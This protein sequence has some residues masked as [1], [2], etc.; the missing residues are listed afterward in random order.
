MIVHLL[1][2]LIVFFLFPFVSVSAFIGSL[3]GLCAIACVLW[4]YVKRK[5]DFSPFI[6]RNASGL[7]MIQHELEQRCEYL[8]IPVFS[9]AE[10]E[11]ATNKFNSSRK[12]G[13][14]GYGTVYYGKKVFHTSYSVSNCLSGF[15]LARSL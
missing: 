3:V 12:L 15:D 14:G 1:C 13:D 4:F 11:E 6:S 10:L 8:G 9:Y 7:S 5:N 2:P